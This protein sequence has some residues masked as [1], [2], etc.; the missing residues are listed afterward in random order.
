M[1]EVVLQLLDQF[2]AQVGLGLVV[3]FV[4]VVLQVNLLLLLLLSR[5]ILEVLSLGQ[6]RIGHQPGCLIG[7]VLV[8]GD[9]LVV[10]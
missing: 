10:D 7:N 8:Y 6:E 9:Q 4:G 5:E 2:G 1:V 3:H